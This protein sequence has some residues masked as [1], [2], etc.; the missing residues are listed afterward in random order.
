MNRHARWTNIHEPARALQRDL[1]TG[2]KD[3]LHARLQVDFHACFESMVLTDFFLEVRSDSKR[4]G[5]VHLLH[6]IGGHVNGLLTRDLLFV[7]APDHQR[8]LRGDLLH[9]LALNFEREVL[10]DE[11]VAV[12]IND[13]RFVLIHMLIKVPTDGAVGIHINLFEVTGLHVPV[14]VFL[15]RLK[16]IVDD[17]LVGI[18]ADPLAQVILSAV[19]HVYFGMDEDLLAANLVFKAEL[20]VVLVVAIL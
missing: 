12:L 18:V 5:S 13:E 1:H 14:L 9:P 17:D 19:I 2:L 4:A 6:R 3:E 10:L 16:L 8:H 11:L 7:V 15:H 20:V